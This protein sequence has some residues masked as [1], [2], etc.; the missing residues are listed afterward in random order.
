MFSSLQRKR[1]YLLKKRFGSEKDKPVAIWTRI[2]IENLGT[3]LRRKIEP[4]VVIAEE[5]SD[6]PAIIQR[7]IDAGYKI[8]G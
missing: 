3:T 2:E 4:K 5:Q 8:R 6:V 1:E 7:L